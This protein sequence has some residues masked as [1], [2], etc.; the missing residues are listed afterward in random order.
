MALPSLILMIAAWARY[1]RFVDDAKRRPPATTIAA[2]YFG[3]YEEFHPFDTA[4]LPLI[5]PLPLCEW[6]I[7]WHGFHD[8]GKTLLFR[9]HFLGLLKTNTG[10]A[11]YLLKRTAIGPSRASTEIR[12]LSRPFTAKTLRFFHNRHR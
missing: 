6:C 3:W 5:E 10:K 2:R 1:P 7:T 4:Q 9:G 11:K 8:A 12:I